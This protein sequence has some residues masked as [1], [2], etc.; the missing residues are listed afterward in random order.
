MLERQNYF[1]SSNIVWKRLTELFIDSIIRDSKGALE[2]YGTEVIIA[3]DNEILLLVKKG[4][5]NKTQSIESLLNHKATEYIEK[6]HEEGNVVYEE[7]TET[8]VNH[9]NAIEFANTILV[10]GKRNFQK[11]GLTE[12]PQFKKV[13]VTQLKE[14]TDENLWVCLLR[15]EE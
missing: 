12:I 13:T 8:T 3:K 6:W 10:L 2:R 11:V 9:K 4:S 14:R 1:A 5:K 7:C 15:E